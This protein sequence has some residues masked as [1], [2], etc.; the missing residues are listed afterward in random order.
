MAFAL[1]SYK[2]FIIENGKIFFGLG[3]SLL[4]FLAVVLPTV[5]NIPPT[6]RE[7]GQQ[8]KELQ[9]VSQHLKNINDLVTLQQS[10]KSSLV[11]IDAAL[12]SKEEVPNLMIQVQS[13]ATESGITLKA[14]QF[15]GIAKV[16]GSAHQKITLQTVLEGSFGSLLTLLKSLENSS[17]IID[18][19][20]LNFDA[21]KGEDNL[22]ASFGLNAYFLD[23]GANKKNSAEVSPASFTS[24]AGLST[25]DYLKNLRIYEPQAV[26]TSVG[27]S[28]PFR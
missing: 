3:G 21:R 6:Y 11:L 7:L 4:L 27:K 18:V 24:K 1:G 2:S 8:K 17:R 19:E 22:S 15:G 25:L 23:E 5:L 14:V 9:S 20:S 16:E 13:I 28:N 10:L 12:P 26:S